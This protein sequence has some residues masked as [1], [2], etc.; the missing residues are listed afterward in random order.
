[1]LVCLF[2]NGKGGQELLLLGDK[3]AVVS[4]EKVT[5]HFDR[6]PFPVK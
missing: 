2:Y 3:M 6:V 5:T 1:M 4:P